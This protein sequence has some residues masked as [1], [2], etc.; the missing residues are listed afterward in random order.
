MGLFGSS[1]KQ[2]SAST[3]AESGLGNFVPKN[4]VRFKSSLI[5]LSEP[6]QIGAVLLL[7]GL[8]YFA[9]KHKGFK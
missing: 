5:D 6:M 3:D 9:Y 1:V 7:L 8:G 2:S 4:K